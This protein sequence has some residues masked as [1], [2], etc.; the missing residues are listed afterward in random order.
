MI[1]LFSVKDNGVG[2]AKEHHNKIF[3]TFQSYTKVSS[4]LVSSWQLL[5]KWLM[6]I[7]AK[8]GLKVY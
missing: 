3:N 7:M 2:I 5:K 4:Q 6:P 8:S 1:M